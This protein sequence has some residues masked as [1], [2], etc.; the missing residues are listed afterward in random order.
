M[1]PFKDD[2]AAKSER[3]AGG[4][5][6]VLEP[7]QNFADGH[8]VNFAPCA[9]ADVAIGASLAVKYRDVIDH[10]SEESEPES[11]INGS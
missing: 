6:P 9:P 7:H 3:V 10:E 8:Y 5:N 2:S 4:R 11:G 1:S